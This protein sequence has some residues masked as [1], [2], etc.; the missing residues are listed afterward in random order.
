MSDFLSQGGYG[1]YVWGSYGLGLILVILE[2]LWLRRE[3]LTNE[4]RVRRWLRLDR[5][6]VG[7][8]IEQ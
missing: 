4:A 7:R 6:S 2:V 5:R 3:R 8:E 1:T